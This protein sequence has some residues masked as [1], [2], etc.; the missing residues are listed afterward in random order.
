VFVLEELPELLLDS[1]E[2]ADEL[3]ALLPAV[4]LD[5]AGEEGASPPPSQPVN[6]SIA[7]AAIT[8]T[9]DNNRRTFFF[10]RIRIHSFLCKPHIY[11]TA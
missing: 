8:A 7:I 4:P 2:A 1:E 11:L 6:S 9:Q 5:S 3:E 10:N